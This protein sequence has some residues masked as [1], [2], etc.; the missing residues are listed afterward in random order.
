LQRSVDLFGAESPF[1][2]L[3]PK[4]DGI[5]PDDAFSSVPYEKGFNFLYYLEQL[6]G[7][8]QVF[9]PYMKEYVRHHAGK[10]ISTD[11]WKNFLYNYMQEKYGDE[12]I[13]L[14]NSVD[15][16]TWFH[17]PGMP[18]VK[19]EFDSSLADTA[20]ELANKW[21]EAQPAE[22][23]EFSKDDIKDFTPTQKVVFLEKLIDYGT[24]MHAKLA[25]MDKIYEFSNQ[26]NCEIRF[27][28]QSLCLSMGYDPIY[29]HV[30]NFVKEQGRMKY[31]R[32]LY[33]DLYKVNPELA[34]STFLEQKDFYH[35]IASKMIEKDIMN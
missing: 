21:N 18:L 8:A 31:V 11:D 27:T 12:K 24:M 6:L 20:Y 15:W 19:N 30:V 33:R 10:S 22:K 9:E 17:T 13:S 14:L 25:E 1:T 4:I 28:W 29:E 23:L 34:K 26:R 5:D 16:D 7:G 3:C 2:A 35:P 32:P